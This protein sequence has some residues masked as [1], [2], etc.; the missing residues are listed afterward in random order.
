LGDPNTVP[1]YV[2]LSILPTSQGSAIVLSWLGC[3]PTSRTIAD[4][5]LGFPDHLLASAIVH[6]AFEFI[7]N[8][9]AAPSWWDSL[10][11]KHQVALL[12]RFM[13]FGHPLDGQ[14]Q[15][16]LIYGGEEYSQSRVVARH[17]SPRA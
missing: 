4:Q 13:A 6:V 17:A 16:S 5:L 1:D 7:E 8:T 15:P 2:A 10:D 11:P 3:Q 14:P 9:F 12:Q